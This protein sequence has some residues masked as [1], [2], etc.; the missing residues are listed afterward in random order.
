MSGFDRL[1]AK[2]ITSAAEAL[3]NAKKAA[4]E[5]GERRIAAK[6]LTEILLAE[7]LAKGTITGSNPEK[8]EAA[9]RLTLVKEY[10][11]LEKAERAERLARHQ[12]DLALLNWEA[13]RMELRLFE[14]VLARDSIVQ[15]H[16]VS[17]VDSDRVQPPPH[18]IGAAED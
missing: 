13:L 14:A 9:A 18:V 5:A 12:L 3:A 10:G 7:G 1:Q 11:D 17:V 8:R 15:V 2:D 4:F 16:G 6:L